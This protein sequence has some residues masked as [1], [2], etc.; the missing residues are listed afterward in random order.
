MLEYTHV[1]KHT[2]F[3]VDNIYNFVKDIF[4]GLYMEN[5]KYKDSYHDRF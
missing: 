5:S 4:Q 1:F 3:I 2:S